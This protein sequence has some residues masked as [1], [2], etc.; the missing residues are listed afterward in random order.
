MLPVITCTIVQYEEDVELTHELTNTLID[1]GAEASLISRDNLPSNF[2]IEDSPTT[3]LANAVESNF[4]E[5]SSCVR[6]NIRMPNSDIEITNVALLILNDTSSMAYSA[7]IGMDVLRHIQLRIGKNDNIVQLNKIFRSNKNMNE[8][9]PLDFSIQP[10]RNCLITT[11]DI[12]LYPG[13]KLRVS[14]VKIWPPDN[15]ISS[16]EIRTVPKLEDNKIMV[17]QTFFKKNW[18]HV[19]IS[20]NSE[21]DVFITKNSMIASFIQLSN[22]QKLLNTLIT[23][24]DLTAA[25]KIVHETDLKKWIQRRNELTAKTCIDENITKKVSEAPLE[26]RATLRKI[27]EKYKWSLAR[28]PSDAGMSQ[29]Y[30]ADMQLNGDKATFTP[31]YPVKTD[32]IPKIDEKMNELEASGIVEECCSAYNSPVLFILKPNGSLRTVNNY[33]SGDNSI[34]SRLVMPRYPTINVRVLLQMVANHITSLKNKFPKEKIVFGNF[35][36]ANAFYCLALR[37]TS[38]SYTAFMYSRRQ[39][40]YARM[41]QG[42]SSS[43]SIFAAFASKCFRSISSLEKGYYVQNYQDDLILISTMDR[44]TMAID[45]V[46]ERVKENNLIVRIEKCSFYKPSINFLGYTVSEFGIQVP[47]RRVK[48]LLDMK[49]P[50]TFRKAQQYQGAFNYYLR[51][52]PDLSALMSPLSKEI[53]KG[54]KYVL[55]DEIISNLKVLREKIRDGIGTAHLEYNSKNPDR[56]IF[57]AADTSLYCSGGVIGNVTVTNGNLDDIKIAAYCSRVLTE[58]ESLLASRARELIGIQATIR[59]FKDMIPSFEE[60]YIFTDHKSLQNIVHSPGLRTSGSTRCRS[61][62]A[63]ILEI[64]LSRIFF[65]PSTSD[66]IKCVDSLSRINI[67]ETEISLETFNPKVYRKEENLEIN[68]YKLRKRVPKVDYY[69]VIREQLASEKFSKIHEKLDNDRMATINNEIYVKRNNALFKKTKNNTELLIIP[70]NLGRNILEVL[71]EQSAHLGAKNLIRIIENEEVWIESKTKTAHDV[72][73]GCILCKLIYKSTEKKPEDMKIR[74]AFVPYT[75][76]FTDIIEIRTDSSVS[77][78]ILTFQDQ[79][80]RKVTYRIVNNKEA[81]TVSE[82]LAELIAEVGGQGQMSLCSDN[83]GEFTGDSTENMLNSLNVHHCYISPTNSRANLCERFHKELRRILKTTTFNAKNAKHKIDLSVSIYNNRPHQALGYLTPNQALSNIDPPKYFCISSPKESQEEPAYE[84][85]LTDIRHM[86]GTIAKRHLET[87]LT[88]EPVEQDKYSL[89][90]IVVLR[91][92]TIVGHHRIN[93]GPF[94]IIKVK[95][96]NNV[97]LQSLL[98][99]KRLRRNIRFLS[100]IHMN[101]EDKEKFITNNSIVFNRK[102]LEIGNQNVESAKS[103][104]DLTFGTPH[105]DQNQQKKEEHTTIIEEKRYNLRKRK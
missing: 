91:E 89:N 31:P 61:A 1:T 79:F 87:F 44:I 81:R 53:A 67:A 33:S 51:Q 12:Y 95:P 73:R 11:K 25:E 24:N 17:E 14:M 88:H 77:F 103:I 30:L 4:A 40:R 85:H 56:K 72:C 65:V 66:I 8:V 22:D 27:I 42:L 48:T 86:Q 35:D 75:M 5:S 99:G 50:E 9:Q 58:Q 43:P 94:I 7:I 60:V 20:N 83:G 47:E 102:T 2:K 70:K 28:S 93:E 76:V 49:F 39:L 74:P 69:T 59:A 18:N 68:T 98:T 38:R 16:T 45:A 84:D 52:T 15:D 96:N 80:S 90:D 64:P 13:E 34:N 82:K 37:D 32:L 100:K 3:K 41:A 26:H 105:S 63:D 55:S 62:F 29:K 19:N 36:L 57:I 92:S 101:D 54:K 6:C 104:L 71:H 78:N 46:F 23:V 97:E 10:S 21:K